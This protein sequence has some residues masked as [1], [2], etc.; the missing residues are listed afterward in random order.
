[1]LTVLHALQGQL[2]AAMQRAFPEAG[3]P[4][5]PMALQVGQLVYV[6]LR[7]T[8]LLGSQP[9]VA[10]VERLPAGWEL[11]NP[12]LGG[13]TLPSWA[14]DEP[15][16]ATEHRN[17]RDDRMESF[18]TLEPRGATIVYAARVVTAG[19][20][21]WPGALLEAMYDPRV[22]ARTAPV[23]VRVAPATGSGLL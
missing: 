8:S 12:A 10:L 17:L 6:R 14:A 16:W 13:A 9:D 4:L 18:G 23:Q 21:T 5:D 15:I 20:F 22:R 1:M 3:Q 7:L 2:L 11:E 19:G